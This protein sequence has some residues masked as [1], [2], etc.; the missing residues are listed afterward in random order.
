VKT[1]IHQKLSYTKLDG[2]RA[3]MTF[4]TLD[5]LTAAV[6]KAK[7]KNPGHNMA[8][9]VTTVEVQVEVPIYTPMSRAERAMGMAQERS[10]RAWARINASR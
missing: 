8:E 4:P 6:A 9:I 3:E 1:E 7:A 2:T 10:D 5:R